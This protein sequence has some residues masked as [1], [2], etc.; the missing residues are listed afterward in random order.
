MNERIEKACPK[1][2]KTGMSSSWRGGFL[3][4]TKSIATLSLPIPIPGIA[5]SLASSF[6][7]P[8]PDRDDSPDDEDS[9]DDEPEA[10]VGSS[11]YLCLGG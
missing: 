1:I 6:E 8:E 4:H 9:E 3:F 7:V 2:K 5:T 10:S 11:L